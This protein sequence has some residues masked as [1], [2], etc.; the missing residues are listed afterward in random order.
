[1]V[2]SESVAVRVRG[3]KG[4]GMEYICLR[5]V[6][7]IATLVLL[8]Q[9][10]KLTVTLKRHSTAQHFLAF[11]VTKRKFLA[12]MNYCESCRQATT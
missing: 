6:P 1:M 5:Q 2:Y 9:E 12:T 8:P 3:S 7:W 11:L 10:Y 4:G